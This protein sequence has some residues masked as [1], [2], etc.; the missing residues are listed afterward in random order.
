ML[1]YKFIL[2]IADM[3]IAMIEPR[4]RPVLVTGFEPYGGRGR[5][6]AA[7]IAKALDGRMIAG[8]QVVGR[9]LPVSYRGLVERLGALIDEHNPAATISLG[10]WPGE[11][12]IRLERFGLNLA[13]FEIADNDGGKLFQQA[14]PHAAH[15]RGDERRTMPGKATSYELRAAS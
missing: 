6:P 4:Q 11:P 14:N 10:L 8:H 7:E 3:A 5:N 9:T 12:V 13:D 2:T 15:W 1:F